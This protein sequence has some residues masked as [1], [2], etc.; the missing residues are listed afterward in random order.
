[1]RAWNT[2]NARVR[3]HFVQQPAGTAVCIGHEYLVVVFLLLFDPVT[4][5]AGDPAGRVMQLR[6]K[7]L[8]LDMVPVIHLSNSHQLPRDCAACDDK[9]C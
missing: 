4:H 9:D 5:R 2:L 1:M 6:R 8:N 7:A 3:Q